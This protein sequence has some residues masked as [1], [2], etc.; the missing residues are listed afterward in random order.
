MLPLRDTIPS[1]RTPWIT[2]TLIL[3]NAAVLLW[4]LVLP[5]PALRQLFFSAGLVPARFTSPRWAILFL[6][7][8]QAPRRRLV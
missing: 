2:R 7:P 3:V 1:R 6:D 5:E 8:R 4:E